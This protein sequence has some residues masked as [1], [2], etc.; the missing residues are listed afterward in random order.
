MAARERFRTR[1]V[2]ACGALFIVAHI[3]DAMLCQ[4]Q[5]PHQALHVS[6]AHA[7]WPL[8]HRAHRC[9]GPRKLCSNLA[10]LARGSASSQ[11]LHRARARYSLC[12][13]QFAPRWYG[14]A[15]HDV[16]KLVLQLAHRNR[17]SSRWSTAA[18]DSGLP[19]SSVPA[20]AVRA[21]L[22]SH[23]RHTH[24]RQTPTGTQPHTATQPHTH[25][26]QRG[27]PCST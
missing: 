25:G 22:H 3:T 5:P 1:G 15:R 17:C 20:P 8:H 6:T 27:V 19:S 13:W 12:S 24:E 4:R 18:S 23:T 10:D 16:Q 26:T 7:L 9:H 11:Y 21:V 2:G 14:V